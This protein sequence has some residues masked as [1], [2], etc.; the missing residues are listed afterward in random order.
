[1]S[2][3]GDIRT[4]PQQQKCYV[5]THTSTNG[6]Y[7][8]YS[9]CTND[10]YS[11]LHAVD[12]KIVRMNKHGVYTNTYS[13]ICVYIDVVAHTNATEFVQMDAFVISYEPI[14]TEML[15]VSSSTIVRME[16]MI[17]KRCP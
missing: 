9:I 10:F 17:H 11:T 1:M 12:D 2:D 7:H 3:F 14:T 4:N 16:H 13:V 15:C 6:N 8:S 5:L